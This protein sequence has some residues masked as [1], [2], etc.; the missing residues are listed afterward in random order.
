MTDAAL[1]TAAQVVVPVV[2]LLRRPSGPRDRQL[3]FGDRVHVRHSDAGWCEVQAEKD[4]YRGFV[5]GDALG[6]A[7]DATHW[8]CALS[9]HVYESADLK[10]PNRMP[11]SFGCKI[12]VLSQ[13]D[14][15]AETPVGYVPWVHVRPLESA[16]STPLQ[17]AKMF[18]GTPYLW[19]GNSSTGIDCSGLVQAAFLACGR[20]CPGD[21]GDQETAFGPAL[22]EGSSPVSGDLLFW[23]GHVA[24]VSDPET[25]LHA[26]GQSMAVSYEPL[27]A[28]IDRIASQGEGAVTSHRRP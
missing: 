24:F 15:F 11:L 18:L 9:T 1:A 25:I 5:R 2:D 26:N 10:S 8:V 21:S 4:G 14:R 27:Q 17:V 6:P 7:E 28:A 20:A 22:P 19:G 3:L 23:K 16:F 13:G 12:N